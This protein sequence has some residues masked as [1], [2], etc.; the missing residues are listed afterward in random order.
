MS[1][2]SKSAYLQLFDK[3]SKDDNYSFLMTNEQAKLKFSDSR[4]DRP[5]EFQAGS[6]K[7]K[8]GAAYAEEF[9]LD[10]RMTQIETDV[11]TNAAD[12]L[13]AQNQAA[14]AAIDV[15]YKAKD[16]QIDAAA[17]AEVTRASQA[18]A[19]NA[20]AITAEETR[21]MG[22][23]AVNAAAVVTEQGARSAA[24]S[25]EQARAETAEQSLQ[26]QISSLLSNV[27]PALIDSLS[28][29]LSHVNTADA[30]LIATISALQSSHDDLKDRVDTLT[31]E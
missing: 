8:K 2:A 27:D 10:G 7:F 15:A 22:V 11:A 20:A 30:N 25:S 6:Y 14:I 28:E 1:L 4:S 13:P 5:M 3:E 21:A 9:D 23:E 19:V 16:A 12:P 17:S 24:V 18:E 29:L 26:T 31:N